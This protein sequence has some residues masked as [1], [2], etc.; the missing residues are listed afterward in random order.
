MIS[1]SVLRPEAAVKLPWDD[2]K[3]FAHNAFMNPLALK[4]ASDTMLAVIYVLVAWDISVEPMKLVGMWALQGKHLLVFPFLEALPFNYAA[5]STPV[6]HPDYAEEVLPAFLGAAAREKGLPHTIVLHDLDAEG[7]EFS[8]IEHA[9]GSRAQRTFRTDQRPIATLEQGV[10]RSGSTRKKLR[11]DW[12]RLAAV[13]A[14]DLVNVRSPDAIGAALEAFL[15]LEAKGWKGRGGTAL[16]N[17]AR[18]AAFARRLVVDLAARGEASVALLRLDGQPVAAQVMLYCG[19]TAYTWKIAFDEAFGKYTPGNLL[20]D[21]ISTEL[22]DSGTV[23]A[24]DSCARGDSFMASLWA[25]RKPMVD[26]VVATRPGFSLSFAALS[27]YHGGREALKRLRD[28]LKGR[29]AAAKV[30]AS[31]T[32]PASPAADPTARP[33]DVSAEPSPAPT[34]DRAA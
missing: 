15:E 11:Q 28:N 14:V 6:V 23:D 22:L 17:N 19:R 5:L 13:G 32:V 18:D 34:A 30:A 21:R 8:A 7:R 2:L 3:P 4:A 24:I 16:L 29:R 10:K 31:A 12:N 9:L 25:G 1:V 33:Q 27:A 26:M 20:V